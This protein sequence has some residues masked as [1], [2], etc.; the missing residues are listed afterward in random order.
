MTRRNGPFVTTA[1]RTPIFCTVDGSTV[2]TFVSS[3]PSYTGTMSMPMLSLRG[4]WLI[5]P[6]IMVDLYYL[7]WRPPTAL[8]CRSCLPRDG[9]AAASA[10]GDGCLRTGINFIP[11]IGQLPG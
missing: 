2:I 4:L 3:S 7:I 8:D 10:V 11:Q 6:S 9:V 5:S 1:V